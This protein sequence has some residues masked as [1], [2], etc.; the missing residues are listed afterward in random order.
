MF[1]TD[2]DPKLSKTVCI[3]FNCKNKDSLGDIILNGNPL[4][5]KDSVKHIGT[6]LH[7]NGTMEQD[8]RE[9][10]AIFIQNCMELNQEYETLTPEIRLKLLKL[11][12]CHYTNSNNWDF[13]SSIFKQLVRSYNVNL[14]VIFDLPY[15]CH[16]WLVEELS[17]GRH[18]LVLIYSKYIQFINNLHKNKRASIRSLLSFVQDDVRSGTGGNLRKIFLDTGVLVV[19]G[20]THK[21][22]L[23]NFRVYD[24]PAGDEWKLPLLV[25]LL[26][27]REDNWEVLYVDENDSSALPDD[28]D[29]VDMINDVC[30]N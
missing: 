16:N 18:A 10:R 27:I 23:W 19:P 21:S 14:K 26:E 17:G 4:P 20:Q 12:N 5:W 3:A 8:C 15:A 29:I 30:I 9:Q 2:P 7:S 28:N 24:T 13:Q 25:S 11:Y 1:S 22:E 6:T